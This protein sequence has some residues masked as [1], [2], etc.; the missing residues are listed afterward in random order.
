MSEFIE[1]SCQAGIVAIEGLYPVAADVLSEGVGP[2]DGLA[3]IKDGQVYYITSNA[4]DLKTTIEKLVSIVTELSTA[5]SL[6][7]A[8][9][10]GGAGSSSTPVAAANVVNL[11]LIQAQLATLQ[12]TLK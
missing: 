7:D 12:E 5:L 1:A 9:P 8:K 6:I 3:F 11:G 4:T 10:T 2:S